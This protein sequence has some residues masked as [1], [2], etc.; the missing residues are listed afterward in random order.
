MFVS[1]T[2]TG[3]VGNEPGVYGVAVGAMVTQQREDG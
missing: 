3:H 1:A 2:F